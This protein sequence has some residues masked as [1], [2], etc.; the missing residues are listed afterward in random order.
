M[1][2]LNL[3]NLKAVDM[4]EFDDD[5]RFLV[6]LSAPPPSHCPKCG[7]IPNLYK[8]GK[9]EQLFFDNKRKI[10]PLYFSWSKLFTNSFISTIDCIFIGIYN[11][12]SG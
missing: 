10:V 12:M 11:H 5:Y 2:L 6:E 1:D 7:T 3:S 9:K 4:K 8:H